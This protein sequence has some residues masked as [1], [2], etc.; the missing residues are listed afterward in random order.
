MICVMSYFAVILVSTLCI[1]SNFGNV[2][3][4]IGIV[5]IEAFLAPILLRRMRR[6]PAQST[7]ARQAHLRVPA[8]AGLAPS[9]ANGST[10]PLAKRK[11]ATHTRRRR[12]PPRVHH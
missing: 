9:L 5:L 12:P 10:A 1:S 8:T 7:G 2:R 4:A 3:L 11:R 6:R